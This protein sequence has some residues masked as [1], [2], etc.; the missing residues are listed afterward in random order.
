MIVA[1]VDGTYELFRVC[2]GL[3]RFNEGNDRMKTECRQTA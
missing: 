1:L 2:Y 3:R